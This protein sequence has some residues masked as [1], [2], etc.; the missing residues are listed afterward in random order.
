MDATNFIECN[1]Y[2]FCELNL[3]DF[4]TDNLPPLEVFTKP[5][6]VIQ[7]QIPPSSLHSNSGPHLKLP[8]TN[9]ARCGHRNT[10]FEISVDSVDSTRHSET[11]FPVSLSLWYDKK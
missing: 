10:H 6:S 9:L 5:L 8:Q 2:Q 7:K 1:E 4:E 11:P 3:N